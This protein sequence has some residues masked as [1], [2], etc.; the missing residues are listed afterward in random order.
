MASKS[1]YCGVWLRIHKNGNL[2]GLNSYST[3]K[4]NSNGNKLHSIAQSLARVNQRWTIKDDEFG[5]VD[6]GVRSSSIN[7][8]EYKLENKCDI[9][10]WLKY[11]MLY[12][13]MARIGNV[14]IS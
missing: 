6:G 9:E 8:V 1:K 7:I 11:T 5:G 13:T 2:F 14:E 10:M 4:V 12:H 3:S